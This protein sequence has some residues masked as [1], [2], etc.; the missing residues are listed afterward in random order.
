MFATLDGTLEQAREARRCRL[1][2]LSEQEARIKRE[3]TRVV[4]EADDAGDWR[5]AGCSSSAQWLARV[6]SSDYHSSR[7]LLV[8][9]PALRIH[10]AKTCR[11]VSARVVVCLIWSVQT[12]DNAAMTENVW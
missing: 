2:S 9:R 5:A 11:L 4:R 12:L 6:S 8:F 7:P 3:V 1:R 10:E